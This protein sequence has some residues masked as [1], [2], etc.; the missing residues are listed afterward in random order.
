MDELN[1]S[2]ENIVENDGVLIAAT[3]MAIVFVAL[4]LISGF[5]ACLPKLP[6]V[7]VESPAHGHEPSVSPSKSQRPAEESEVIAAIGYV[8]HARRQSGHQITR[9]E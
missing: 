9:K 6:G 3:G 5:I 1:F 8:L 2:L 7:A 4:A